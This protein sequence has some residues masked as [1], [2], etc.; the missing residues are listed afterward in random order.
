[1]RLNIDRWTNNSSRKDSRAIT[2]IF[3]RVL[4]AIGV[5]SAIEHV[6]DYYKSLYSPVDMFSDKMIK[7]NNREQL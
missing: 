3:L 2:L 1:M 6:D 4:H 7:L 5:Y